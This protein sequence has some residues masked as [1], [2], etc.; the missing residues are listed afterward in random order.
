MMLSQLACTTRR[1]ST[2][3]RFDF[4]SSW[5]GSHD[6][7]AAAADIS[8]WLQTRPCQKDGEYETQISMNNSGKY[9][10]N[11]LNH[12]NTPMLKFSSPVG[13]TSLFQSTKNYVE[14]HVPAEFML[15]DHVS[16]CV[17][18]TIYESFI[19][20]H[21]VICVRPTKF[22]SSSEATFSNICG[23]DI[24]CFHHLVSR[25]TKFLEEVTIASDAHAPSEFE[26][27][28]F[29]SEDEKEELEGDFAKANSIAEAS[30]EPFIAKLSSHRPGDRE[31]AASV[32]ATIAANGS[33]GCRRLLNEMIL[34]QPV[35]SAIQCV[36]HPSAKEMVVTE[37]TRYPILSL[38]VCATEGNYMEADMAQ[39]LHSM[40]AELDLSHCS[41]L[42]H[43]EFMS[44]LHGLRHIIT[45]QD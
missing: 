23:R 24:V 43:K 30:I 38:V 25:A 2:E 3:E 32:L 14:Y 42:V 19:P 29:E 8:A 36:L 12:I 7:A 21:V 20:I 37:A 10:T 6:E 44:A 35:L 31:E 28:D 41:A 11:F 17:E 34:R 13:A 15:I 26:F 22:G 16:M 4:H 5:G 18:A 27:L 9:S 39:A 33:G 1:A 40:L 45:G